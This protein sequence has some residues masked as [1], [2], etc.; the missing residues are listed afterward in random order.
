MTYAG[1]TYSQKKTE[2]FDIF[3]IN[4]DIFM[5]FCGQCGSLIFFIIF[6]Y[7]P[8]TFAKDISEMKTKFSYIYIFS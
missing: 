6:D 2:D 8:V 3:S 1:I 7:S 4:I 5:V